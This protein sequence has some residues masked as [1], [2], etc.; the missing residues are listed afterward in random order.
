MV[1]TAGTQHEYFFPEVHIFCVLF[2][3]S[4]PNLIQIFSLIFFFISFIVLD[5]ICRTMIHFVLIFPYRV[6]LGSVI[7]FLKNMDVQYPI[8][9]ALLIEKT[10]L[11][12]SIELLQITLALLW[13]LKIDLLYFGLF[14]DFVFPFVDL[15]VY[16]FTNTTILGDV[17]LTILNPL[18][19]EH[20]ISPYL[21][22][23][24][25][26]SFNCVFKFPM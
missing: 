6:A 16:P 14:L 11:S 22:R 19:H 15:Y 25:S 12:F 17:M 9:I 4:L 2:E 13:K 20:S 26:I 8:F 1:K 18:I 5:F 7:L 10:T 3:I 23:Y 24:S 21:F